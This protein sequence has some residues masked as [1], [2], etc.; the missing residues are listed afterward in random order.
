MQL[1]VSVILIKDSVWLV[2]NGVDNFVISSFITNVQAPYLHCVFVQP[3]KKGYHNNVD[4]SDE[5]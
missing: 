5:Y 2:G 1:I 3:T 4:K